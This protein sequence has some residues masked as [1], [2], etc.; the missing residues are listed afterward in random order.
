MCF[1]LALSLSLSDYDLVNLRRFSSRRGLQVRYPLASVNRPVEYT[2]CQYYHC[3]NM[4]RLFNLWTHRFFTELCARGRCQEL[5][6]VFTLG[7]I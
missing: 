3:V 2:Q 7:M 1:C 6:I 5:K 4:L